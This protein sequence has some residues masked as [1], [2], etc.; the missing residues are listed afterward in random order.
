MPSGIKR[1]KKTIEFGDF[2]TSRTLARSVCRVLASR[3]LSPA[4]VVEPTCGLGSLLLA[5]LEAFPTV[6]SA[7]GVDINRSHVRSTQAAVAAAQFADKTR[8]VCD[9]FFALDWPALLGE[10][11]DPLLVIGNP[12]WVTNS[13][14]SVLNSGNVPPKSN[15]LKQRGLDAIT[16]K[17]NFDISEWML[18]HLLEWLNGR[19]AVVAMLC[20]ATVAR[21]ALSQ[22]WKRGVAIKDPAMYT[23]DAEQSF[24][25][26]VEACLLVC[27]LSPCSLE[28]NVHVFSGL[29]HGKEVA[30]LGY[31]DGRLISDVRTHDRWR[32]LRGPRSLRWRSGI[33]HD[34]SKVIE[35]VKEAE[36]YRNGL[37]ELIDLE[38][39]YLHPMLKSSEVA[40]GSTRSFKRWMLVTQRSIGQETQSIST[41]APKTWRYL[42]SHAEMLDR[43]RS[44]VYRNH[45]RFA[46]FGVGD[47]TFA[48]WKVAV[49]GLY[50]SLDFAVVGNFAGKPVVLDD[51]CYSVPCATQEDAEF[52]ASLLNC[53]TSREFFSSFIFWEA[54]R[55]ITAEILR[56][57]DLLALA[58]E[59]GVDSQR[60][61]RLLRH[62]CGAGSADHLE[63]Q[64]LF[65][66]HS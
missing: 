61:Q 20:K 2:Q 39:T 60:V 50:K 4:S 6:R 17:A 12:P 19:L 62:A 43:R 45:P 35:L 56:Q 21:K 22:A 48:P 54:K 30:L 14:L 66:A 26:S 33:K 31:R 28:Q 11:P 55:P 24:G 34:C 53:P 1:S 18:L 25:A 27:E 63:Q 23:I 51:T 7:L 42:Q 65:P 13:R 40:K 44:S 15:F 64:E 58:R 59:I 52:L 10:L 5:A 47:Y 57:L 36:K 46:V 9:D 41:I 38:E 49:S 37:G 32:H 16:G 3:G 29:Q 8:V